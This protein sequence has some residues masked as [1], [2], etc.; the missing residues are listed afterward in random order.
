VISLIMAEAK[1]KITPADVSEFDRDRLRFFL[2]G[3]DALTM[4]AEINPSLAWL[5][6]LADMEAFQNDAVLPAWVERNFEDIEAVREVIANLR[7]FNA[8]TA[9][10]LKYRL[11]GR[12]RALDPLL[13][14]CWRLIIRHIEN[15]QRGRFQNEWFGLAPRLQRGDVSTEVLSRVVDVLTPKLFISK[16]YDWYDEGDR[17][18]EKPTDLMSIEYNVDDG[19]SERDF[20]SV[21]PKDAGAEAEN[22]LVV[23]LSNALSAAVADATDVGVEGP[24]GLSRTDIDVPSVATHAQNTHHEGFL[25]IVRVLAELWS[26]LV[27][28]DRDQAFDRLDE[29]RRSPFRLIHRLALYAAADPLIAPDFAADTLLMVPAAELFFTNSQVEVHR[30]LRA[31]WAEFSPAKRGEIERRIVEGPPTSW[32]KDGIDL[33]EPMDRHRFA[34]LLDF[35]RSNVPLGP[36]AARLLVE[37]RQRHPKWADAEP[38]KAGF[39]IWQGRAG[40]LGR[41]PRK[42]Q[43]IPTSQLLSAAKTA[44]AEAHFMEGDAWESLC[45]SQPQQ[46]FVGIEAAAEEDR[47]HEW[48]WRPLLWA[49]NKISDADFL[50]RMATLLVQWPESALFHETAN[51]A[52]FWM[53]EVSE[54]LKASVLWTLWD[55]IERRA[56]RRS[57][58]S[59]GDVFTAAL[60]D[61]AGHLASVLLKRTRRPRGPVELGRAMRARYATLIGSADHS[62]LLARVRLSAAIAFLF[63]RAPRWTAEYILLSYDWNSP[64]ALAMWS[65]RKFANHIG[66]TKLFALVKKPFVELFTRPEVPAEDIRV[67]S[68]WLGVILI[69][70]EAGRIDYALTKTEV[71]SILRRSGHE[72][73]SSFAHRLAIEMES[74]KPDEKRHVWSEIVRPVFE[75][76]WPLDAELQSSRTTFKLVQLLLATGS[77]FGEAAPV[78]IPFIRPEEARAHSSIFSI[79]EADAEIFAVAPEQM[80]N[81]LSAVAGDAAHHSLYGM[82]K[83]LDKLQQDAPNLADTKA[84]QK[85]RMQAMAL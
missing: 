83:A 36:D 62:A 69:A 55:F 12:E 7:F 82:N 22:F 63:E 27:Q 79:A 56:P 33:S 68:D 46:A 67:F 51:G 29:W 41:Q 24:I 10:T 37:I 11:E 16:R 80:L 58:A 47:W 54:K 15:D 48:A 19:I 52:A 57:D 53:D 60:N 72:C 40:G 59:E 39:A 61:P 6:V 45:H 30:L 65:A 75:G 76:S 14:K 1:R 21:W 8:E 25:P 81:L 23:A 64:D 9:R 3:T 70:N 74:A 28:N 32:F 31:R 17:K 44:K 13:A 38:E 4:L 35:E 84:F 50:N 85:L 20:F 26:A 5:P 2:A 49:S 66:S 43:S 73:L 77:A 42:L 78:V 18:V 71:R 34:L